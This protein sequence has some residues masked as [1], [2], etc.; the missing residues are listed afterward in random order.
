[1]I[2]SHLLRGSALAAL[3]TLLVYTI[4]GLH[5]AMTGVGMLYLAVMG[6]IG[7]AALERAA[8]PRPSMIALSPQ[9]TTGHPVTRNAGGLET[10]VV[11]HFGPGPL[12]VALLAEYDRLQT[13]FET[14][15]GYDVEH[16]TDEVLHVMRTTASSYRLDLDIPPR[17]FEALMERMEADPRIGTCSG[18]PYMN[19]DGKLVSEMC[20]DEN[21][22]GMP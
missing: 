6:L 10:A 5:V 7:A 3:A 17:Y 8:P 4:T 1:M 22:V 13:R 14:A 15:S 12:N 21:S 19:L 9:L 2:V 18:K 20:G 16:R 11:G